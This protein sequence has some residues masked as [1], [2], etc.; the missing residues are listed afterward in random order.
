MAGN[1]MTEVMKVRHYV[2]NLIYRSRGEERRIPSVRQLA[3]EFGVANSTV[4]LA[5]E[6]MIREKFLVGK[7]GVGT[8]TVPGQSFILPGG[9]KNTPLIGICI[10]SGDFF[11]YGHTGWRL[12]AEAGRALTDFGC[13][14]RLLAQRTDS[15]D[16]VA[17]EIRHS[18]L[19][20]FF[21]IDISNSEVTQAAARVIP[22]VSFGNPPVPGLSNVFFDNTAAAKE[23][24]DELV[25]EGR[26]R[27]FFLRTG[28]RMEALTAQ[29]D[30][31][32]IRYRDRSVIDIEL[33]D[34]LR[35]LFRTDPPDCLFHYGQHAE[36]VMGVLRELGV[37]P[38]RDCRLIADVEPP[39]KVD[40]TG[41][42]LTLPYETAMEKAAE[43]LM[44]H[45]AGDRNCE[46]ISLDI[47]LGRK[48][49]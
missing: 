3:R 42:Y 44:R 45:L 13:N 8:F 46:Q 4:Q 9:G 41:Y 2:M 11:Y 1:R 6:E 27:F 22:T 23:L 15:P 20:G 35:E 21:A 40:Y 37:D 38:R 43:L 33:A 49:F 10:G 34:V 18:Y 28:R 26:S 19:D 30:S 7:P 47:E 5:L 17:E 25:K 12:V 29:L 16:A 14:V 36:L 32:R 48:G 39:A 24:T 31:R